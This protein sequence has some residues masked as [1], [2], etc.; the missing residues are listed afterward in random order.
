MGKPTGFM[1]ATRELPRR[2]PVEERIHDWQEVYL[3]FDDGKLKTQAARCMDCGVPFCHTGC[4]LGNIIP[5]WNDLVFRNRWREAIERLHLTNNFPEFT[6]RLCPAPCEASCVLGINEP[7]VTIKNIEQTI[8]DHAFAEG[9][10]KPEPAHKNT[11]KKVAVVGSG[12]AGLACAQQLA[13]VGHEVTVFERADRIGGLLR[14]GIPEFKMEKRVLDRRLK[15]MEAEG[16]KFVVNAH[17]GVTHPIDDL[18]KEFDAIALCGGATHPRDLQVPGRELKG[19]YF[20]MEYLPQSNKVCHGDSVPNQISAK[21]KHVIIIGGGDT[22][23][24]CLGTATR[25]GAKSIKQY[26]LLPRPPDARAP[27][28]PWP[29]WANIFRSSSAH[30]ECECRD[31]SIQT[32]KLTGESGEVKKLHAVR[33]NWVPN[34]AG[35]PPKPEPIPGTEFTVDAELILL[36]MGFLGPEK[37]TMLAQLGVKITERGNVWADENKM[38]SIPGIFTAGDMTRGQSLIVW[39]I[40]EGRNAAF[41]I[42]KH[43]MGTTTLTKS[44]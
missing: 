2:R 5:D 31:F 33:L 15:Q 3:P 36:A 24:D 13:R 38:T 7:A 19:T 4:P 9:W 44:F 22:G 34:P 6:G 41:G 11:G 18:R 30:E 29:Q 27:N 12:P 20:A 23:A 43:L 1:E 28:N 17:I 8:I 40:A 14:Y 37:N 10:V 35:G 25:Q 16:V 21:G 32:N 39:A 42:D 26:E